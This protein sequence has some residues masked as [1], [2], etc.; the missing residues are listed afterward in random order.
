M[1]VPGKGGEKVG[2]IWGGETENFSC[3]VTFDGLGGGEKKHC[4][5]CLTLGHFGR[6]DSGGGKSTPETGNCGEW[7]SH[8]K[9]KHRH[10]IGK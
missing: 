7:G 1:N 4:V 3:S 9:V 6:V 8:P 2:Q 10:G 5:F